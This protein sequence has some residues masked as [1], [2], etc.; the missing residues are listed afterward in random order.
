ML[1][2]THNPDILTCLANLSNEEVFTSP[3]VANK[4]L[5]LLPDK[6]WNDSETKFLD[7]VSK[8]GV[9]LREITKRLLKGLEVKYPNIEDRLNH[10]LNNQVFGIATTTLTAKISRRSLYC[11]KKADSKLSITKFKDS[12]GNLKFFDLQHTWNKSG[13]CLFCGANQELYKRNLDLESYAYPFIHQ[14]NPN[15]LFNMKFD[16]VIGNPPYQMNDGGAGSSASPIY[17][18]FVES[19]KKLNPRFI[20]FIIPARWYNGGKGLD[21]FR[22]TMLSDNR[23]SILH[24]FQDTKDV[25]PGLNIRGGICYFLWEKDYQGKCTVIN[26]RKNQTNKPLKRN[27]RQNGLEV[28]LRHNESISIF[29]KVLSFKEISFDTL[30]SSRKPFGLETNFKK[31]NKV[32]S[33]NEQIKLYRFGDDGYIDK[34]LIKN[35]SEL[36]D[37]HKIFIPYASPGD[38]SYPH[39]I[40]SKPIIAKPNTACTETYLVIGP[41]TSEKESL[42]VSNYMMTSFVRFM[43]LLSKSSQ[44]ITKKTYKFVPIQN[45]E[46]SWDDEKL[47][48]KYGINSSEI[49]FIDSLIRKFKH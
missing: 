47:Y 27:L 32:K 22:S 40:L 15:S 20:S 34:F 4:M 13:K 46:E 5:D 25:F 11:A 24:D 35:Y 26:H 38:D 36:I 44:H 8:S 41:F 31:F 49:N 14:N 39:L 10:I 48:K 45:F 9:F 17:H 30:V 6:L 16:V 12:Q 3:Q 29:E 23:I 42:N 1:S 33:D 21:E 19:A 28:F 2:K 43:I 18:K 7:P 37:S